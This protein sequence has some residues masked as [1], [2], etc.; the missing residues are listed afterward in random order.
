MLHSEFDERKVMFRH[1]VPVKVKHWSYDT[2][3][4]WYTQHYELDVVDI[5]FDGEAIV[6][7]TEAPSD[8]S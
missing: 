7:K 1:D 6:I 3:T 4:G 2:Y 8:R 5:V